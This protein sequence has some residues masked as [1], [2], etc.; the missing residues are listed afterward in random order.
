M[1]FLVIS[2][3]TCLLTFARQAEAQL[4]PPGKKLI[5]YG[6]DVPTPSFMRDHLAEM[7]TRPF[8]GII[9]KLAGGYNAF[10]KNP[11]TDAAMAEDRE[12][13]SR[14]PFK[15]FKD[16]FFLIWATAEP[17]FDWYDDAL[18]RTILDNTRLI[19]RTGHAA[20]GHGIC[21]DPEPY[22]FNPWNYSKQAQAGKHSFEEY[23]AKMR[24]RGASFMKALES[25]TPSPVV[26]SFFYLSMVHWLMDEPDPVVVERELK[27]ERWSLMPDFLLG[28]LEGASNRARFVDGNEYS[29]YYKSSEEFFRAYHTTRGRALSFVPVGLREKYRRQ[30]QAG[31]AL[32]VDH[33]FALRQPRRDSYVSFKMTPEEQAKWFEHNTYYALYTTDEYVWCYSERMNWWK[34]ET[35][36]G[37]EDAILR[38]RKKIAA[39]EELGYTIEPLI[40]EAEKRPM[41]PEK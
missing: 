28:M 17:G 25:E 27:G 26:L 40:A 7:E 4:G 16:N 8:D 2:L 37:L 23:R 36:A 31:Q 33:L 30:V 19:S 35:P 1:R 11:L 21:F 34:N 15:R 6:W 38:A 29:Y 32:Y 9:F 3:L 24:S 20:G 41:P 14:L 18:W 39:G 12:I 13:L 22:G 10:V 5:E